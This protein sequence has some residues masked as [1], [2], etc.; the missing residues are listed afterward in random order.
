MTKLNITKFVAILPVLALLG[1]HHAAAQD[2]IEKKLREQMEQRNF[3]S[4]SVGIVRGDELVYAKALGIA[5]R[6]AKREATPE[7]LYRIGS[8]SKVFTTTLMAILRDQGTLQLDDP[9]AKYLPAGAGLP[10]DPRGAA[11]ITLR[12]L[13]THTSGLPRQ[14]INLKPKGSDPYGG[15]TAALLIEGLQTTKLAFPTGADC[16]YSN[17]GVGLLGYAL[18][19]AAK[20]PYEKLLQKHILE[21]LGMKHSAVRLHGELKT[22]LAVG[23][24]E[25]VADQA[26]VDWDLGVLAPAGGIASN[27]PDLAKFL[28]LQLKAGQAEVNVVRGGTLTELHTPQRVLKDWRVG[29]GLGWHITHDQ[30]LGEIVWHNGGMAG[31]HSYLAFVRDRNIGVIVLTNRG[32]SVDEL[33]HWLLNEAMATHAGQGESK[34]TNDAKIDPTVKKT[35]D[36]LA[37]HLVS[38]P[39][40]AVGDLFSPEFKKEIPVAALKKVFSGIARRNG[41]CR[42]VKSIAMGRTA[43]EAEVVFQFDDEKIARALITLN[44]AD[45]PLIAGLLFPPE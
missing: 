18:E 33:G 17:L 15:Y 6:S 36:E 4:L 19:R 43:Q 5:D 9:V 12:H 38:E 20:D 41:N 35:A 45:P 13:A 25:S 27:V 42:G 2:K 11:T 16:V 28:S 10:S 3:P 37:K 24:E 21:P 31:Y 7:T 14:P 44:G 34:L 23:Y 32:I 29:V 30:K 26:A 39:A 8:I 40:D 22:A 1:P